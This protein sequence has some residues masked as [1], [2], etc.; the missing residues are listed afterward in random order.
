MRASIGSRWES[1]LTARRT[2]PPS[3]RDGDPDDQPSRAGQ[4][5]STDLQFAILGALADGP[6]T[7][8]ALRDALQLNEGPVGR[9]LQ[10]L[11]DI[12]KVKAIGALN[13]RRYAL[14]SYLPPFNT[15]AVK[16]EPPR[17]ESAPATSWW[18]DAQGSREEFSA[19]ARA[20]DEAQ[21]CVFSWRTI[22]NVNFT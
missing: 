9:E 20:R 10:A 18:V 12:G 19:A 11:R 6:L 22:R 3:E 16:T 14:A 15:H 2:R 4:M 1:K 17:S 8:I 21:R 13:R 7:K 5:S